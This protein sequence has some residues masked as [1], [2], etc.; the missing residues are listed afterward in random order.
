MILPSL[1]MS[2]LPESYQQGI[3]TSGMLQQSEQESW[4]KKLT[5]MVAEFF[6]T[7]INTKIQNRYEN[8]VKSGVDENKATY[9][10]TKAVLGK[11]NLSTWSGLSKEDL[12]GLTKEQVLATAISS[13]EMQDLAL[14]FWSPTGGMES[15]IPIKE[16]DPVQKVIQALKEAKPIR[17]QQEML[18]TVGRAEKIAKAIAVGEKTAGEKGF[19]A[20]LGALKGEFPKVQFESIR[21]SLGK[22]VGERQEVIDSLFN[23]V[24]SNPLISTWEKITARQGLAKTFEGSVPTEGELG[25]LE[26]VFGQEF[27][28]TLLEKRP[29]WQKAS[30]LGY[31]VA[32]IPRAIMSSYDLSAPLRQGAFFI[33]KPKQFFPAFIDMFKS[34]GSEKSFQGLQESIATRPTFNLM[35][36]A[37]LSLT[38][39]GTSLTTREE[40]FMSNLAEKIPIVGKGIRASSRAYTGFLNKLRADVF[41]DLITKAQNLGL[42]PTKNMDLTKE[43]ANF[44]NTSTGRGSKLFNIV[45][46]SKSAKILNTAFFSP[47]LMAS[48]TTLLNPLYYRQL[49]LFVRKEA[50]KSLFSFAGV[51]LGILGLAKIAGAEV[52]VDPRSSDFGKIKVGNTRVD[53]FAGFQQYVRMAG[54]L[55]TGQ[56]VSS[57][58][59][60]ITVYLLLFILSQK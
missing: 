45:D 46:I 12:V 6:G 44:I 17:G 47:R 7:D 3:K 23:K 33:G 24:K 60:K 28:K 10:S 4:Y 27:T 35:K 34:F 18:Y 11:G 40:R 26:K 5:N 32:N 38:D 53:L 56:Y 31:Q 19:Y 55:L 54:Q 58:T 41:D 50:L 16:I 51:G 8:L 22:T 20:E 36:N 15:K 42:N 43:I 1:K 30:E 48:R 9:L 29:F 21:N 25:L 59:G 2:Q 14:G 52:G 37:K 13:K 49:S 57:T 39:I